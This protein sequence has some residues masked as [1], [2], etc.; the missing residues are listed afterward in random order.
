MYPTA[1]AENVR[2]ARCFNNLL[3]QMAVLELELGDADNVA[4]QDCD[5]GL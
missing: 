4:R 3:Q 2:S 1:R 5:V